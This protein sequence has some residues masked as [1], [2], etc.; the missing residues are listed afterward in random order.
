AIAVAHPGPRDGAVGAPVPAGLQV[1]L[2]EAGDRS[3]AR[4]EVTDEVRG[5]EIALPQRVDVDLRMRPDVRNLPF[6]L[7]LA[8]RSAHHAEGLGTEALCDGREVE[9]Q[10]LVPH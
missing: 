5:Q 3:A 4:E 2:R 8:V 9:A 1:A 7:Q 6:R 10:P